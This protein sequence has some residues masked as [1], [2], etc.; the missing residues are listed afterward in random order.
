MVML[1]LGREEGDDEEDEEEDEEEEEEE[2]EEEIEGEINSDG[3]KRPCA[4][5]FCPAKTMEAFNWGTW[6]EFGKNIPPPLPIGIGPFSW[7]ATGAGK[8]AIPNKFGCTG[9]GEAV[10][11]WGQG[12]RKW[13]LAWKAELAGAGEKGLKKAEFGTGRVSKA[14]E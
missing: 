8:G 3:S 2:E 9:K 4:G 7:N 5:K 10:E 13:T 11:A 6:G 12:A 14:E 1:C